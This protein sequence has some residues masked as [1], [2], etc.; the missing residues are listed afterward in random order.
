VSL[1]PWV[2][3]ALS[4]LKLHHPDCHRCAS[5][6]CYMIVRERLMELIEHA[7]KESSHSPN[8]N[9]KPSQKDA[10]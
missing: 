3:Q 9:T 1:K 7:T 4:F 8:E 5:P 2:C 6:D 10:A